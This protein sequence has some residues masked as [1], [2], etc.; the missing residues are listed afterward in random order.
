MSGGSGMEV[1]CLPAKAEAAGDKALLASSEDEPAA[2]DASEDGRDLL[3]GQVP[4]RI[5]C[6]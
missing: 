2:K 4:F 1:Q 5:K 3:H 6:A